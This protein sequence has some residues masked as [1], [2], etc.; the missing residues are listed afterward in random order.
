M[1][2]VSAID[3]FITNH[4]DDVQAILMKLRHELVSGLPACQEK[5]SYGMQTLF[6]KKVVI[7][8][9]A[10]KRYL[11]I[12]PFPKTIVT[13]EDKGADYRS[14]KGPYNFPMIQKFLMT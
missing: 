8:Q 7:R 11:G 10:S 6:D 4:A 12:Y 9:G 5:I 14:A 2:Q 3:D 13:F 1:D